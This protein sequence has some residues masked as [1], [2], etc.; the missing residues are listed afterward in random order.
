MKYTQNQYNDYYY[1]KIKFNNSQEYYQNQLPYNIREILYDYT[2]NLDE[3][4]KA[5]V[6]L[7]DKSLK[8]F[9]ILPPDIIILIE[10]L[11]RFNKIEKQRDEL[12]EIQKGKN[13]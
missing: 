3:L 2:E 7:Y 10:N 8:W 12:F 11:Y 4:I 1:Y 5:L 13:K 9:E 6:I